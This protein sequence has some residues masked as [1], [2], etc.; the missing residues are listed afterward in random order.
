MPR[1]FYP[2]RELYGFAPKIVWALLFT[3][4]VLAGFYFAS[5]PV[6]TDAD[7]RVVAH[8]INGNTL[9]MENGQ[10][11]RL[12]GVDTPETRHSNRPVGHFGNEA[13]ALIERLVKGKRVRL[14][15]DFSQGQRDRY[16][17]TLAY[18][19]LE[20]GVLLNA[21]LLGTALVSFIHAL[22][23]HEYRKF[24]ELEREAR[25]QRRGLW[26]VP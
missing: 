22:R 14:Q 9:V 4:V 12:I 7:F 18:A 16:G 23:L 2:L 24:R 5:R 21:E 3:I 26:R 20:S 13:T 15:F 1:H 8:V 25:E 10:R 6:Y 17:H 19:F 11:V